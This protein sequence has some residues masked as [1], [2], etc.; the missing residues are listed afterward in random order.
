MNYMALYDQK[1]RMRETI[2]FGRFVRAYDKG[3]IEAL[4]NGRRRS[5]GPSS[6]ENWYE[7]E[8]YARSISNSCRIKGES[9]SS[10]E[11]S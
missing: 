11:F 5:N 10:K 1:E 3:R 2:F 9:I 7:V 6:Q 4:S 8:S